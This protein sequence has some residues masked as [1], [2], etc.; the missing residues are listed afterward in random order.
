MNASARLPTSPTILQ[1]AICNLQF[2]FLIAAL[3][4]LPI[5]RA[6]AQI[7]ADPAAA[8]GRITFG[9]PDTVRIRVGAEVE[10]RRGACRNVT[11]MVAAPLDC[12]EQQVKIISEDISSEVGSVD[13]RSL[14][15]GEVKQMV[16][17]VPRLAAGA[18]AHA[19]VDFEVTT[20]PILPPEKTDDLVIPKRPPRPV[21]QF[22]GG[23]P[24]IETKHQKIRSLAKEISAG[25]DESATDWERVEAIYDC[26]LEKVKYVEGP[27]KGAVEALDDAQ[28]DCQGRSMLFIALCR[29]NKVPARMVWVEGHAYPEFYLEDAAGKGYWFP[30]ESAGTRAFGEMPLARTIL[31][32]GDNFRVPERPKDRLRYA[33]DYM[34]GVPVGNAGRPTAKFIREP[35]VD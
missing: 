20:R 10:A 21:R 23:S 14:P 9:P 5:D 13:Y 2:A 35:L 33:S 7:A 22:L 1:F 32:K 3:A 12:P 29:A 6:S 34:I 8:T 27:D 17:T 26:V 18:S 16:I 31:Q 28:A 15:G 24:Y 4:A 19:T 30:C 25:L 11:L